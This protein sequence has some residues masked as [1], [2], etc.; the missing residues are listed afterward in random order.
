MK[1]DT[2]QNKKEEEISEVIF[3]TIQCRL[4]IHFLFKNLNTGI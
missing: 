1:Q 3:A 2:L 4:P